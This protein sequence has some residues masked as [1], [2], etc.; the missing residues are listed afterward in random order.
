MFSALK[1]IEKG[2]LPLGSPICSPVSVE[3]APEFFL[4]R[5]VRFSNRQFME[6]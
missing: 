3:Q 4:N 1:W 5:S 2:G 6:D